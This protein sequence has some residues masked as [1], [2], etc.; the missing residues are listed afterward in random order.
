M[1]VPKAALS[2]EEGHHVSCFCTRN[3][4]DRCAPGEAAARSPLGTMRAHNP[5]LA[6]RLSSGTHGLGADAGLPLPLLI[7]IEQ[8]RPRM[9]AIRVRLQNK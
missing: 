3:C 1:T 5:L 6:S 9:Q 7:V 8:R 4:L 2:K